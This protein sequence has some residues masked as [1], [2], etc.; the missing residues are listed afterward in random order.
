MKTAIVI[1]NWNGIAFLQKYL[2]PLC[3]NTPQE[4]SAI[5]IADNGSTDGSIEWV[6]RNFPAMQ[7][8]KFNC[9]YGFTGG[10][11][12]AMSQIEAEYYILLNSD[13]K[14]PNSTATFNWLHPLVKFM[15]TT[16]HAGICQPKLLSEARPTFF[17]YAG[18]CGGF[19][20]KYGF[21]F[22]RG[23]ILS[24]AE[25]DKGQYNT[26]MQVFWASGACMIIRSSLW[27]AL[28]GLDESFFAHMEEID[29]C[30]RAQ[31]YGYEVWAIPQSH[32]FHVGGGT[33]PN[34]SP[35]KL[36]FNYRNNLLMLYKNLPLTNSRNSFIFKRMCIDG[37]SGIAYILQGKFSYFKAVLNAHKDFR[38]MKKEAKVTLLQPHFKNI[39]PRKPIGIYNKSIIAKFFTG[40]RTFE[41]L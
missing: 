35:R 5:I 24:C 7:I 6:E 28:G 4:D 40:K 20:D 26:P 33:L 38:K 18:A 39:S 22:C 8:I 19:I 2:S 15:D 9:N 37:L 16:P 32:V 30:W 21:P 3:A 10:Y 41:K 36:Y 17:E 23:R 14:V 11:N 25:E 13:I 27:K 1:L 29:L 31:L 34:N 12:R